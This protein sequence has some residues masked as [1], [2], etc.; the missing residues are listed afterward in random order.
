ME[1]GTSVYEAFQLTTRAIAES[2]CVAWELDGPD[3]QMGTM[4]AYVIV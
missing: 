2:V 3:V 4:S 1:P